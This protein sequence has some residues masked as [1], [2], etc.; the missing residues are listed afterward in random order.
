V[1][2]RSMNTNTVNQ[3]EN[4]CTVVDE[5]GSPCSRVRPE[6]QEGAPGLGKGRGPC[7]SAG[8]PTRRSA[9]RTIAGSACCTSARGQKGLQPL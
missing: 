2:R 6:G 5:A 7:E 4:L 8:P 1:R 3:E 9:A